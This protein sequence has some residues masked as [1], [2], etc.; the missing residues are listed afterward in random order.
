MARAA[1]CSLTT[2]FSRRATASSCLRCV[3]ISSF[4][5][6][7][8][9]RSISCWQ[10]CASSASCCASSA[11]VCARKAS[12]RCC[13]SRSRCTASSA[14]SRA[15]CCSSSSCAAT[16]SARCLSCSRRAFSSCCSSLSFSRSRACLAVVSCARLRR[17]CRA[18]SSR[19]RASS[20]ARR[21]SSCWTRAS[22]R[23]LSSA[24]WNSRACRCFMRSSPLASACAIVSVP[25]LARGESGPRGVERRKP[26][27]LSGDRG[28]GETLLPITGGFQ[29]LA[30]WLRR[31]GKPA[32]APAIAGASVPPVR[33][34]DLAR[35]DPPLRTNAV[36]GGAGA[37]PCSTASRSH[38][39]VS[40]LACRSCSKR[41]WRSTA[42]SFSTM[43]NL[44][45]TDRSRKSPTVLFNHSRVSEWRAPRREERETRHSLW[46]EFGGV[47]AHAATGLEAAW[48]R[49]A[50]AGDGALGHRHELL[51]R[52]GARRGLGGRPP[53]FMERSVA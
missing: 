13:F 22:W 12:A 21:A 38:R 25:S 39:T 14:R 48:R 28:D 4:R 18:F 51:S 33:A 35:G 20:A 8:F 23:S 2:A 42:A 40:S 45:L 9:S 52:H 16:C 10:L 24:S 32:S 1:S 27:A 7:C 11:S 3:S 49:D 47:D 36:A 34:G 31:G 37:R 26:M 5:A 17:S 53:E 43:E 44:R 19:R 46:Q 41:S 30:D 6:T 50:L 15:C 29:G